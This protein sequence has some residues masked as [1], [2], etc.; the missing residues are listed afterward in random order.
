M[1]V[2]CRFAAVCRP[3]QVDFENVREQQTPM[4]VGLMRRSIGA[5]E[6][7]EVEEWY[8]AKP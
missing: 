8:S 6:S 7:R 1:A 5:R 2:C 3:L 4:V